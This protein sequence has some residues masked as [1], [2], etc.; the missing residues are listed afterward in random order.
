MQHATGESFGRFSPGFIGQS[1][2]QV[3]RRTLRTWRDNIAYNT[4]PYNFSRMLLLPLIVAARSLGLGTTF[5]I[6]HMFMESELRELRG[7]PKEIK[8]GVM[9]PIGWP[10]N[11]FV[12]V[13][14]RPIS[15]VIH[16][17]KWS[18]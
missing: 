11:D 14:R 5:T 13:K 4:L 15:R 3:L 18:D 6:F 16:W 10:Q 8:F 7:I 17:D 1:H 2:S 9:I 12:K